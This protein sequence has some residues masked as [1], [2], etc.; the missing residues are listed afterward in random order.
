[1]RLLKAPPLSPIRRC[2]NS[3][4]VAT[5]NPQGILILGGCFART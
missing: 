5:T 3:S 1:M 2:L 4:T